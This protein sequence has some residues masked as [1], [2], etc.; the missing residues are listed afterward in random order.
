MAAQN[1]KVTLSTTSS[2]NYFNKNTTLT[3]N[4]FK[5]V[6]EGEV[7]SINSLI[8]LDVYR[9]YRFLQKENI[10]KLLENNEI[11]LLFSDKPTLKVTVALPA[12][13]AVKNGKPVV[14]VN[15]SN[16]AKRY[17]DGTFQIDDRV[18]FSLLTAGYIEYIWQFN[19][20]SVSRKGHIIYQPF[21]ESYA[22]AIK[23]VF[24]RLYSIGASPQDVIKIEY[25]AAKFALNYMLGINVDDARTIATKMVGTSEAFIS[26]IDANN[27]HFEDNG[28]ESLF[29]MI[30]MNIRGIKI[31]ESAIVETWLKTFGQSS[32]FALDYLPAFAT[33]LSNA[34]IGAYLNNQK[35]VESILKEGGTRFLNEYYGGFY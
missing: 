7:V 12:F 9:K 22:E 3:E 13:T 5:L 6:N 33:M 20:D 8:S 2:F 4:I 18:L 32:A 26:I 19:Y 28:L 15:I 30:G 35:S 21:A 29:N 27:W 10:L 1:K 11:V 23:K 24:Y 17:N 25:F 34:S 16:H 14:F 31:S